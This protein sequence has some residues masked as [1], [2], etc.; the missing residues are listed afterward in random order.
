MEEM[1]M[2]KKWMEAKPLKV[3]LL[4]YKRWYI[5]L[6]TIQPRI[7]ASWHGGQDEHKSRSERYVVLA[8]QGNLVKIP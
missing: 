1:V 7:K 5:A 4:A 8:T 3:M 6:D 2:A